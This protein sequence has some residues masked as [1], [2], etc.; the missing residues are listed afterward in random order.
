MMVENAETK[1]RRRSIFA[2]KKRSDVMGEAGIEGKRP[3]VD[4]GIYG[5]FMGHDGVDL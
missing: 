2:P 5:L 1:R 4:R 3:K